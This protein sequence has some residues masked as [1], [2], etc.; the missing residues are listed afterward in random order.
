MER[1]K[2]FYG[3]DIDNDEILKKSEGRFATSNFS[4]KEEENE[5]D[6][7]TD[8]DL[9]RDDPPLVEIDEEPNEEDFDVNSYTNF[10]DTKQSRA[11]E[12][13][14]DRLIESLKSTTD[15]STPHPPS[16]SSINQ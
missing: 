15:K 11:K 9:G 1:E 10:S 2:Q 6:E 16:Q 5:E 8:D 4:I 12:S 3:D 13:S 7:F 14:I